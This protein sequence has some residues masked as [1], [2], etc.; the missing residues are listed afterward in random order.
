MSDRLS[1][2]LS[3]LFDRLGYAIGNSI[4]QTEVI[5]LP[6]KLSHPS[7]ISMEKVFDLMA[8]NC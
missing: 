6:F 2:E 3:D 8:Y 7:R 4:I 5:K 1:K